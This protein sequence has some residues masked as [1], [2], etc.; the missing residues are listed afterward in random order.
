M[1]RLFLTSHSQAAYNKAYSCS[2]YFLKVEILTL[3]HVCVNYNRKI[4]VCEVYVEMMNE[5]KLK[6]VLKH[7][8]FKLADM[9]C[10]LG[11]P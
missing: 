5:V 3:L 10:L 1:L 11:N 9:T 7:K 2:R 6:T 4:F 8:I